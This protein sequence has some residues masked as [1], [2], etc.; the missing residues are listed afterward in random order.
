MIMH[1]AATLLPQQ[2]S[3]VLSDMALVVRKLT[4]LRRGGTD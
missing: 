4:S 2:N 1:A 3:K